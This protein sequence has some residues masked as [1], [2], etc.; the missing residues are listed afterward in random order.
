MTTLQD[1][2]AD[3][4]FNVWQGSSRN[5]FVYRERERSIKDAKRLNCP[6]LVIHGSADDTVPVKYGEELHELIS[7]SQ[8]HVIANAGHG[9]AEYEE[10]HEKI[11]D[12]LS[13]FGCID[14]YL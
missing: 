8:L 4:V 3:E 9:I 1:L 2:E 7:T 14:G 6:T 11:V 10:C 5:L 12:W 13:L